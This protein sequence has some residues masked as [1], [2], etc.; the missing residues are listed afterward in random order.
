VKIRLDI[1]FGKP[2]VT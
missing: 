1:I 2:F